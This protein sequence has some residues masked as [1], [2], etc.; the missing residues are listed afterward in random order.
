MLY[1]TFLYI[2][3]TST[4]L[5]K[6]FNSSV[7]ISQSNTSIAVLMMY[8]YNISMLKG[9]YNIPDRKVRPSYAKINLV[10]VHHSE[11]NNEHNLTCQKV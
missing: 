2:V 1:H 9:I 11:H 10:D 4:Y 7:N 8:N 6:L 5:L 3:V